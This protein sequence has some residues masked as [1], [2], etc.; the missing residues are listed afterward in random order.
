MAINV[1]KIATEGLK[2]FNKYGCRLLAKDSHHISVLNA[3][4]IIP[5]NCTYVDFVKVETEFGKS[6]TSIV[7][8][9]DN[10]REVLERLITKAVD[11]RDV[12]SIIK[13]Y[14]T[15]NDV[16]FIT[17]K[18]IKDG[19]AILDRE[20]ALFRHDINGKKGLTRMK[21]DMKPLPDGSRAENQV[22]EELIPQARTKYLETTA[23]R[24]K[25]GTL[26][27]KTINAS[28]PSILENC[29]NDPYLY[30]RNYTQKDFA[31]SASYYAAEKQG[32]DTGKDFSDVKLDGCMG[33]YQNRTKR[34]LVDSTQGNKID[35]VNTLNHEY[36]HKL[37]F[38][39]ISRIQSSLLNIFRKPEYKVIL[40]SKEKALAKKYWFAEMIYPSTNST[41]RRYKNNLL[42]VDARAAGD[43]AKNEYRFWSERLAKTF[44]IPQ[45]MVHNV[46][47]EDQIRELTD[48][49]ARMRRLHINE[50]PINY[51]EKL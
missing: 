7:T 47:I 31:Q 8:F 12:E 3:T 15:D 44:G 32:V 30:I 2:P 22:Y 51:T 37:Q 23:V 16:V 28:N 4:K 19:K 9:K 39:L 24:T 27:K 18:F 36:R 26:Y 42:E 25:D 14:T 17:S 46:T 33:M 6:T 20:E 49:V 13:T 41:G 38:D 10:S 21:L 43:I 34:V 29:E 40:N 48:R 35:M 50:L 11:G 45:K 5:K 1:S